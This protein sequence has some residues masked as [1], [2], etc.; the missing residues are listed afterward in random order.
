MKEKFARIV[1]SRFGRIADKFCNSVWYIVAIGA[2]CILS[3]SFNIPVVGAVLLTILLVPALLFCKNSF[4]LVPFLTMCS[5]VM[6]EETKPQS[7]YYG[8]PYII[9]I[10]CIALV[11]IVAAL[12]FNLIYY[13]K[14]KLMFKRAYLTVSLAV[15]TGFL[16]IG[17][18]GAPS[19]SWTGVTM[20]LAIGITMFLPYSMLVNCGEYDGR[21]SIEYFAWTMITVS[22]V[23]FAA[24]IKQYIINDLNLFDFSGSVAEKKN[25]IVFGYAISNTAAAFVVIALPITFYMVY[26][27]KH[28]YLFLIAIVVE[29]ITI[30]WTYSR[31]SLVVAL[32]GTAIVAIAMCFKKKTGRLGYW[33]AFGVAA[34]IVIIGVVLL[35]NRIWSILQKLVSG[36]IT[37]SGRFSLWKKGFNAWKHYPVFGLGIW[38]LPP[39]NNWYYSFHCTPLTY[40]YC[41]GLFGLAAYLYHRYKTVRLVFSS[42]LTVERTFVALSILA[43]LCN[44]L[45][46]I[47]MT[48]PPH[49]LYYGIMLALIE[50]DV[51]QQKPDVVKPLKLVEWLRKRKNKPEAALIDENT[52]VVSAPKNDEPTIA[53]ENENQEISEQSVGDQHE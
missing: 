52:S 18:L 4:V 23:I 37:S 2:V 27:Y 13:N 47:A 30:Y 44:A 53:P 10:L 32:P 50:C 42:K 25:L 40:L 7:G 48:M 38:Y 21:K 51:K 29:L 34:V 20:A 33:I 24:V 8:K 39:I 43:M 49:L 6:S 41:T 14:W 19:I 31:A 12:I 1:D 36:D 3:H 15:V 17:G 28:G 11:L 26:I 16:L 9:A 5:F 22:V 46:D 35:R 45:L